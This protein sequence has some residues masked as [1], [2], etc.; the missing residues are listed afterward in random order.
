MPEPG[1]TRMT[2]T[3]AIK[4]NTPTSTSNTHLASEKPLYIYELN[5]IIN[6]KKNNAAALCGQITTLTSWHLDITNHPVSGTPIGIHEERITE[7]Y[8][9]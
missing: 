6:P 4:Y 8:I 5:A 2:E 9:I 3:D 1:K 7:M